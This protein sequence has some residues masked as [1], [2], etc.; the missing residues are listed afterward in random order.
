[1]SLLR[2]LAKRSATLANPAARRTFVSFSAPR[3]EEGGE[4]ATQVNLNFTS[5]GASIYTDTAVDLVI[6]PGVSGDYGVTAGHTPTIS[7]L[8]PGTVEI[9]HKA[10]DEAL[11]NNSQAW[12]NDMKGV[13]LWYAMQGAKVGWITDEAY[14]PQ[15]LAD[16][17]RTARTVCDPDE[18]MDMVRAYG[19]DGYADYLESNGMVE[20]FINTIKMEP[21]YAGWMHGRCHGFR[22]IEGVAIN[23]DINHLTV[24]NWAQT[25]P[26]Y[27]DTFDW[28]QWPA[29]DVSDSGVIEYFQSIV[30]LGNPEGQNM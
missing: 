4:E 11:T 28:P 12:G 18:V 8:R 13:G 24:L 3:C 30:V 29:L 16:I 22:S 21:H 15:I 9:F 5:P 14:D 26:F 20:T 19:I 27:N 10:D 25:L 6:I 17:Q 2:I 7:E 1:M 23:H